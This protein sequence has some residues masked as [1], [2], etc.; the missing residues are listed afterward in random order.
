MTTLSD[1]IQEQAEARPGS[2]A[3]AGDGRAH[4]YASLNEAAN[5]VANGLAGAGVGAGDRVAYWAKNTVEFFE[6]LFGAGKLYAPVV[7]LNWR[8]AAPEVAYI[9]N[10]CAA[11]VLVVGDSFV[12]LLEEIRPD[13]RA[14]LRV[15]VLGD[16]GDYLEWL[17]AQRDTPAKRSAE[18]CDVAVQL[19]TSGTTGTPKGVLVTHENL[20]V[21]FGTHQGVYDLD[22]TSVQVLALPVF[23]IG[24]LVIALLGAVAGA[25]TVVMA[26]ADPEAMLAAMQREGIS[27]LPTVPALLAPL[28]ALAEAKGGDLSRVQTV[29]YGA[30]PMPESLLRKAMAAMNANF[31]SG[32]GMTETTA[33]VTFLT[34]ADH[35]LPED[36]AAAVA[37]VRRL[38]SVGR[39]V[40]Q[41]SVKIVEP[42]TLEE[43]PTGVSGELLVRGPHVMKGYWSRPE[44]TRRALLADGWLRTGDGGYL[45]EDG[46]LFLTDRIKDM[47]ISGGENI[48]PAEL[49]NVLTGLTG[50]REVAVIGVPHERWGETP[51]A[52]VVRDPDTELCE[53]DVLEH[54]RANLARY[55]CPTSVEWVEVLPRTPSGKIMKHVLREQ[56]GRAEAAMQSAD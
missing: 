34:F 22:E 17:D 4:T 35:R 40:P 8:L 56:F 26:E 10:D 14:D 32:F 9:L 28:L 7:A 16:G 55:K 19:Y 6:V 47:I 38:R 12:G 23:H 44:E 39:P 21:S 54:C 53:H 1:L 2:P 37:M 13:L 30:S 45:D 36:P 46:Y 18:V 5:R 11:K 20:S 48:Y 3:Y 52:L 49:E 15:L 25:N 42:D 24:G 33:A 31:M 41:I 51:K 27:H 43:R 50:V 29:F